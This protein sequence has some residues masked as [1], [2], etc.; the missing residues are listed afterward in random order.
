M[1]YLAN[2]NSYDFLEITF[3]F[4]GWDRADMGRKVKVVMNEIVLY[5]VKF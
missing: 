2:N 1:S 3:C 5:Q 4:L